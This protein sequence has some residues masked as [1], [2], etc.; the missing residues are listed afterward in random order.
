MSCGGNSDG[1]PNV[2]AMAI[3]AVRAHAG[4]DA[5]SVQECRE[6]F[7]D[8][9]AR[10]RYE[11]ARDEGLKGTEL[12]EAAAAQARR[13][14]HAAVDSMTQRR[15]A[16]KIRAAEAAEAD[17]VIR[18]A[19]ALTGV[20]E[21]S[22]KQWYHV[23]RDQEREKIEA[24][25]QVRGMPLTEE[26]LGGIARWVARDWDGGKVELSAMRLPDGQ[27]VLCIDDSAFPDQATAHAAMEGLANKADREGWNLAVRTWDKDKPGRGTNTAISISTIE[28]RLGFRQPD[29]DRHHMDEEFPSWYRRRPPRST[30]PLVEVDSRAHQRTIAA[31]RAQAEYEASQKP[32]PAP[33]PQPAP[34][35]Q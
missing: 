1:S 35:F 21:A 10:A 16:D 31:L 23:R 26:H 30:L 33:K 17:Q 11:I 25:T 19:S 28:N 24:E 32:K 34:M 9:V 8:L 20:P 22:V 14:L 12:S 7:H 29:P 3:R 27:Q 18:E 2:N 5:P 13:Q 15:R 4:D 6:R